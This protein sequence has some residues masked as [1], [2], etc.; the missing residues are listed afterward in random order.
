[1]EEEMVN[2]EPVGDG[3]DR[4]WQQDESRQKPKE[5]KKQK[6]EKL[7]KQKNGLV[8]RN[9]VRISVALF[10]TLAAVIVFF[11]A[12]YS[13]RSWTGFLKEVISS[14]AS[15]VA[16]C[17][18]AYILNPLMKF[19]EKCL[20]RLWNYTKKPLSEKVRR[21]IRGISIAL[22]EI[23]MIVLVVVLVMMLVPELIS[24]LVGTIN[25]VI[26][27]L[28]K[29]PEW[30]ESLQVMTQI[31][32]PMLDQAVEEIISSLTAWMSGDL[33]G[34]INIA[35]QYVMK[36]AFGIVNFI[37]DFVIG[38]I[39]SMY[40][41]AG[42]EHF[43]GISK[44]FLYAFLKPQHANDVLEVVRQTDKIFGG[45][46]MGK[47]LDSVIIGVICYIGLLILNIPYA[48]V[49]SVIVGVT[50]V[51]P[52]FGPFIGAIPSALL[53]LLADP[54]KGLIFIVFVLV[55]QQV[56]GNIIGPKILGDSTGLSSFWI[57][58][59]ILFAGGMF[60]I[61]G[62]VIGAPCFAV[63]YYLI[64]RFVNRK[65]SGKS[66][67]TDSDAYVELKRVTPDSGELVY[68]KTD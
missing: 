25:Q 10:C 5:E 8:E 32:N 65:L 49:V 40:V 58:F 4:E 18:I 13:M 51:I 11:F 63:F 41:L 7:L 48:M 22:S 54:V 68:D 59:A 31:D 42:K 2:T 35:S 27:Q 17:I 66:L 67:P 55:L 3:G 62:M 43:C 37:F 24:N 12:F 30:L 57:I 29:L 45:F 34:T 44:K 61:P 23:V 1:M 36:S 56:D 60:G 64:K 47:I 6:K 33:L 28:Q 15:V 14:L 21:L 52:F 53:I 9:I 39:V 26:V 46:I 38:I 50:N 19:F 20:A 16:G